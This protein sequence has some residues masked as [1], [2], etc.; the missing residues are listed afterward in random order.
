MK[1]LKNLKHLVLSLVLIS[2]TAACSSD[3]DAPA[4]DDDPVTEKRVKEFKL[5]VTENN[6]G[7]DW[8]EESSI[9]DYN[10][11][12]KMTKIVKKNVSS[13]SSENFEHRF[14]INYNND[15][16]VQNLAYELTDEGVS[17]LVNF[18]YTGGKLSAISDS[19]FSIPINYHAATNSFTYQLDAELDVDTIYFN[20]SND[21]V[22]H[23]SA[24]YG[25]SQ[26]TTNSNEG[27]YNNT[28]L[29]Q[30]LKIYFAMREGGM[31]NNNFYQTKELTK[32]VISG[33]TILGPIEDP[34]IFD[35]VNLVRNS[36]G[37]IESY[38]YAEDFEEDF[39]FQITYTD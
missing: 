2:F 34:Y 24:I 8:N 9:Y 13:I 20:S 36:D 16:T 3:D 25:T 6:S 10:P 39:A 33:Q 31:A 7:S 22:R 12:G 38:A 37:L 32:M 15:G 29:N 5:R 21:I 23:A 14:N 27:V 1:N 26:L 28:S 4:P 19:E 35:V 18:G 30:E 17:G 11:D